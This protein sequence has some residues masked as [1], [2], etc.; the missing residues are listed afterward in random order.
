MQDRDQRQSLEAPPQE[1]VARTLVG[2]QSAF[3]GLVG[4]YQSAVYNL[5]YRMLGQAHDAEDAAQETF[6]RAYRQLATYEPSRPFKTWLFAIACHE[7]IDQLR[8]RR[9]TLFGIDEQPLVHHPALRET[10]A[11]PEDT[12]IM[13]EQRAAMQSLLAGLPPRDRSMI[14]M[15]YWEDLSYQEIAQATGDTVDAV[16]S[17][18]HRARLTLGMMLKSDTRGQGESTSRAREPLRRTQR[19]IQPE[20]NATGIVAIARAS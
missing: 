16:K 20:R 7:C 5:C 1:L 8:K 11:G 19:P 15:R 2:D 18:L 12:A 6:L 9:V 17:R 13:G 4:Q 10:T 14:V 3:A